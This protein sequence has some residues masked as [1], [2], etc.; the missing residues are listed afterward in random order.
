MGRQ[1]QRAPRCEARDRRPGTD[2][3][4]REVWEWS[5]GFREASFELGDG[6]TEEG[7]GET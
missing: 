7:S 6:W 2:E 5:R 3:L 1:D 4:E